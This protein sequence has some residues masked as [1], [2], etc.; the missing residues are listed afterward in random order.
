MREPPCD[1]WTNTLPVEITCERYTESE[2]PIQVVR[3]RLRHPSEVS[4]A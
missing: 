2:N 3:K 1:Y 4:V